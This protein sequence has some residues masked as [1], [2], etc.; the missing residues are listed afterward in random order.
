MVVNSLRL[1]QVA[2]LLLALLN[3]AEATNRGVRRSKNDEL[4][5]LAINEDI[6]I[7]LAGRGLKKYRK[8]AKKHKKRT[9]SNGEEVESRLDNPV[10]APAPVPAPVPTNPTLSDWMDGCVNESI[11]ITKC[12]S[13]EN[14][15]CK[16]CLHVLSFTSVTPSTADGSVKACK[17]N[18]CGDCTREELMPFFECGYGISNPITDT[19]D[20]LMGSSIRTPPPT[21]ATSPTNAT[22]ATSLDESIYDLVNCPAIFPQSGT[23]CVMLE[24]YEFKKCFYHEVGAD[25]VCDCSR[26]ET[27]WDCVG[28]ITN[29]EFIVESEDLEVAIL[30][31]VDVVFSRIDNTEEEL[32]CPIVTPKIGD[33]CITKDFAATE[34]CYEAAEPYPNTLGTVTCTCSNFGEGGFYCKGGS[35]STCTIP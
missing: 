10:P 24:G 30:P 15:L 1:V 12:A 21:N 22:H 9:V 35:L 4:N 11:D 2:L 27:L 23:Q 33:P 25:V 6:G 26:K 7:E 13:N 20:T 16:N 28:T 29:E 17:R 32:L 34:C 18:F 8:K 5:S 31:S 3:R 14:Y 19:E